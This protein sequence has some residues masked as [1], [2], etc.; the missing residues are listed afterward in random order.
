M[1]LGSP[2]PVPLKTPTG[3]T[4]VESPRRG[5]RIEKTGGHVGRQ[6]PGTLPVMS[7]PPALGPPQ[8]AKP[9][10]PSQDAED[11]EAAPKEPALA[12]PSPIRTCYIFSPTK[13]V[14]SS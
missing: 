2:P 5:K 12:P 7:S 3:A 13:P 8:G 14:D 11:L 4:S 10:V 9:I 1:I 6:A